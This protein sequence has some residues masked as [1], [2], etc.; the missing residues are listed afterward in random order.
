MGNKTNAFRI[1]VKT[2]E[3]NKPVGR[4]RHRWKTNIKLDLKGKKGRRGKD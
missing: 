3:G 1:V 4:V 2:P